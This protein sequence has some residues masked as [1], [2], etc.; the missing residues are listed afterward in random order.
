MGRKL[1]FMICGAV[2]AV[3]AAAQLTR[4]ILGWEVE[5]A[6]WTAPHWVSI[7]G[8]IVPGALSAWGFALASRDRLAA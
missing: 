1:Y 3:V 6:G 4:L 7:P 8:A 5:I 2:F